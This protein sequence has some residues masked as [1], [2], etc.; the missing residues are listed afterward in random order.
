[1]PRC[2]SSFDEFPGLDQNG[3]GRN[4]DKVVDGIPFG[5]KRR[6]RA[7]DYNS[8]V[9]VGNA[10]IHDRGSVLMALKDQRNA[11]LG[12]DIEHFARVGKGMSPIRGTSRNGQDRMVQKEDLEI[13]LE[14]Q[15]LLPEPI[16]LLTTHC[17]RP[18]RKWMNRVDTEKDH[19]V[20]FRNVYDS[21]F[22]PEVGL[23]T[24]ESQPGKC[25]FPKRVETDLPIAG[26]TDKWDVKRLQKLERAMK[27]ATRPSIGYVTS[28]NYQL[29]ICVHQIRSQRVHSVG[30]DVPAE[31]EV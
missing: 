13:T 22:R 28:N 7:G 20:F 11:G 21:V 25:P 14:V 27:L 26:D 9:G 23:V 15:G 2:E 4:P 18:G 10:E 29:G 8:R 16:S 19:L 1:M 5:P 12:T 24:Q 30:G 31:M 6:T 17:A 3:C